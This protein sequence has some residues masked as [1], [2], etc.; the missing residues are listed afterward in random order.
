M[1]QVLQSR[2]YV[3]TCPPAHLFEPDQ[4]LVCVLVFM[5]RVAYKGECSATWL[6]NMF[7]VAH[8]CALSSLPGPRILQLMAACA[9]TLA[10]N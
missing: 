1:M 6:I 8:V 3:K 4:H 7:S 5:H 2:Q 10:F 9:F